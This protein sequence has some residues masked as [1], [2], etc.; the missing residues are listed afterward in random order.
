MSNM[1]Y[2]IGIQTFDKIVDDGYIYVVDLDLERF[3]DT[4]SHSKLIEILSRTIKDGR[5]I[6]LIHKYPTVV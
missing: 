2:P 1:K 5:V 4:V 6:S 3:F